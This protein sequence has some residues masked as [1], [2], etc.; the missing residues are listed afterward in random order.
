MYGKITLQ[1]QLEFTFLTARFAN[2][3]RMRNAPENRQNYF[4]PA[5]CNHKL[6]GQFCGVMFIFKK[7]LSKQ[8][9]L[10]LLP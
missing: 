10:Q 6:Y 7:Y 2:K 9:N 8:V 5:E 3:M 1:Y 4:R